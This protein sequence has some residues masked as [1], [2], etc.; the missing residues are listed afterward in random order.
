MKTSA[1]VIVCF[2]TIITII[3]VWFVFPAIQSAITEYEIEE[4]TVKRKVSTGEGY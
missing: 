2:V 3:I 4:E 1:N